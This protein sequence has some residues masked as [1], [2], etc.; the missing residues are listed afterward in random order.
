[1]F[2]R[3]LCR[4]IQCFVVLSDGFCMVSAVRVD[5]FEWHLAGVQD[6]SGNW[7]AP[8]GGG[9]AL[10][11]WRSLSGVSAMRALQLSRGFRFPFCSFSGHVF[12][13]V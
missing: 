9:G 3:K 1:M 2:K 5:L 12:L 11:R 4:D 8:S 6:D 13:R 10:S 7:A